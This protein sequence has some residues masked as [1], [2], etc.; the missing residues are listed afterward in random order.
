MKSGNYH[1]ANGINI[2]VSEYI[3]YYPEIKVGLQFGSFKDVEHYIDLFAN[4]QKAK[5]YKRDTRKIGQSRLKK[6]IKD[7]LIYSEIK[8][9]CVRGGRKIEKRGKGYRQTSICIGEKPC[10]FFIKFFVSGDGRFLEVRSFC[11]DHNH[12]LNE[13]YLS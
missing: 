2:T 13:L 8:Y 11:I 3:G 10:P 9:A 1:D 7:E 4:Y 12:E 5:Y 6:V